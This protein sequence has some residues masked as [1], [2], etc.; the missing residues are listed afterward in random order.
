MTGA[1]FAGINNPG[2][3][4]S[5][6]SLSKAVLNVGSDFVP[7]SVVNEFKA[8]G[9]N[10]PTTSD[11]LTK[12]DD[13]G[14]LISAPT[15]NVALSCNASWWNT[16]VSM[17]LQW[18]GT[19]QQALTLNMHLSNCVVTVGSATITGCSGGTTTFQNNSGAPLTVTFTPAVND[20]L[21]GFFP[22][23]GTY[24]TG[25]GELA[26]YRT[27]DAALYGSG[28]YFTTEY[29]NEDKALAPLVCR[30]MGWV[31][32]GPAGFN[33]EVKWAY[34]I[35]PS[36]FGWESLRY[37]LNAIA[38]GGGTIS[39]TDAYTALS[40]PDT[41]GS[42]T[43]NEVIIG[44]V[45][46]ANL[47]TS[48][49]LI[50]GGRGSPVPIDNS[51]GVAPA[52]GEI[53]AGHIY[54]FFYDSVLNAYVMN[55]QGNQTGGG[56][57]WGSVPIEA[58]I[59]LANLVGCDLWTNIPPWAEDAYAVSEATAIAASL[60]IGSGRAFRPEYT[61]EMWNNNFPQTHWASNRGVA[62]GFST[63][64][65][66]AV[67]GYYGIRIRQIMATDIP[68][69]WPGGA[70]AAS[71]QPVMAYQAAGDTT[72]QSN[73]FEGQQLCPI[74]SGGSCA[75]NSVYNT[76]T[77]TASWNAAPNRPIDAVK[78]LANAPYAGGA[79]LCTGPDMNCSPSALN[80][81]FYQALVNAQEAGQT[82][83]ANSLIDNDIRAGV[84]AQ[85][86]VTCSATTCTT[87][88]AHG[89]TANST[90]IMFSV[91]S[92]TSYSGITTYP[93]TNISALYQVTSTPT[94]TTFTFKPYSGGFPSGSN[95]NAGTAGSGTLSVGIV[96]SQ[97]MMAMTSNWEAFVE[98]N[99]ERYNGG[100]G[101]SRPVGMGN[102]VTQAYEMNLEP[103]GLSDAQCTAIGVTSSLDCATDISTAITNWKNST[104]AA[105]TEWDFLK[106]YMGTYVGTSNQGLMTYSKSPSQLVNLGGGVYGLVSGYMPNFA[107]YQTYTGYRNFNNNP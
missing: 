96:P 51:L 27:S 21:S 70:T 102:L 25:T 66:Q 18:T 53:H 48:P 42:L 68:S 71:Y 16:G 32:Q 46:H 11:F 49:T 24:A 93:G 72:N 94:S 91:A 14:Y 58:Q 57:I 8:C 10:D 65:N 73:R 4:S 12:F 35:Q 60:N 81:P 64:S 44:L 100:A 106:E 31:Q 56:G 37:P 19:R 103:N 5:G 33:G 41:P 88:S 2:S 22:A 47:T 29:V 9:L 26:L 28:Q 7:S 36:T 30:F 59:Q 45:T 83:T 104:L 3:A 1:A 34:R 95:V 40:A 89:F 84:I 85:Q 23:T 82:A 15:S 99:A 77:G 79:N 92:G 43:A 90:N 107:P 97:T 62:M 87:P 105:N 98:A 20:P 50:V 101:G 75:G 54:T 69:V 78:V 63:S 61:N 55:D 6:A 52:I 67:Y 38:G 39:G 86:T 74:A 76:F 17:T 13:S 80:Q